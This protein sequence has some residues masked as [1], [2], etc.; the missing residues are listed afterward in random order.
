MHAFCHPLQRLHTLILQHLI[1]Q[2][3]AA[4]S[5]ADLQNAYLC[6]FKIILELIT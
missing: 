4:T 3:R 2:Q 6:R 1:Q 5:P